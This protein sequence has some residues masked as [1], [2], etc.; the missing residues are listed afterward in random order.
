ML[1][2]NSIIQVLFQLH[3]RQVTVN[4]RWLKAFARGAKNG[5]EISN[6]IFVFLISYKFTTFIMKIM[7]GI[8]KHFKWNFVNVKAHYK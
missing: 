1:N 2:F 4:P 8:L 5:Y 3:G 7:F 6:P